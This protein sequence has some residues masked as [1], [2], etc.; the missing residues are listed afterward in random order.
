MISDD[1][2]DAAAATAGPDSGGGGGVQAAHPAA[3]LTMPMPKVS[4]VLKGAGSGS[5]TDLVSGDGGSGSSSRQQQQTQPLRRH[6]RLLRRGSVQGGGAGSL[7]INASMRVPAAAV[8]HSP[9]GRGRT[10]QLR[11][12]HGS[13]KGGGSVSTNNNQGAGASSKNLLRGIGSS[14]NLLRDGVPERR[15]SVAK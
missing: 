3:P 11:R 12:S 13:F 7:I 5:G 8:A 10:G 4:D 14:K 1:D 15:R 9:G 2:D 6:A